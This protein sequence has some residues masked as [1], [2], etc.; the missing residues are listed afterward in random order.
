MN[1]AELRDWRTRLVV[2][3]RLEGAAVALVLGALCCERSPHSSGA[4][5][6]IDS[7]GAQSFSVACLFDFEYM[8][9]IA[10]ERDADLEVAVRRLATSTIAIIDQVIARRSS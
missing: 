4:G 10:A 9:V 5:V 1:V 3:M 2:V 8:P 6:R 7:S